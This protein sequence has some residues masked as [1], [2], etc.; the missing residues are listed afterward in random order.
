[1]AM[2]N[3]VKDLETSAGMT[4]LEVLIGII[5]FAFGILA[6]VQLQSSMARS[7]SDANTRTVAV[8]IA[9]ETIE[10]KRGFSRLTKDPEGIEYAYADIEPGQYPVARGGQNYN[11]TINVTDYW[12]NKN[13]MSFTTTEPAVAAVSDFKLMTVNVNWGEGPEFVIDENTSTS[14]RLGSGSVTLSEIISSVTS[15]ADAKSATGGTGGIYLPSI[16]YNPGSNPEIISISLGENK[17]KESTKPVPKVIRADS[18]AETTFDVVTY[19]QNAEGATFL[20]REE[21]RA[22]ACNCSLQIPS[23][24]AQG[25]HRPTIWDGMSYTEGEFVSKPYGIS[26]SNVQSKLCDICCRDHHDGGVG[27]DDDANDPGRARYSPFRPPE[28]YVATGSFA[29]DHKHYSRNS[30]GGLTLATTQGSGYMESCRMVRKN[31]FWK[32]AQDLRQEGLNVFPENFLDSTSEVAIYSKYIT[33]AIE[34]YRN[35]VG[36]TNGYE[37]SPPV[38]TEA[39]NM[40]PA[41]VFPAYNTSDPTYLPTVLGQTSQQLRSRGIYVDYMSDRLRV[42]L[43]C[44][45]AG[46][47]STECEAPNITSPLEIMPFYDVQLTWLSRWNETPLNNPADVT[48]QAIATNNTHSRGNALRTLGTGNTTV[49]STVHSGNLGLTATDPIDPAYNTALRSR[50]LYMQVSNTN[51]P[52]AVNE[53]LISGTISSSIPGFKAADVEISYTGAQCNRTNT[54][55]ICVIEI[56]AS[57]PRITVTNYYANNQNRLGCSSVMVTNGSQTGASG[58]TRFNLPG[59]PTTTADIVIKN[60]SC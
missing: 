8:N 12:Y 11:T 27:S 17:F 26:T 34:L 25:G 2:K 59:S 55:Y 39:A 48:N 47:T 57:N 44:L 33:D 10:L 36:N 15:A 28:D 24:N 38:L 4:L 49:D 7:A 1:M 3:R 60:N 22:I 35:Q 23:T 40:I 42:I 58:W 18:L 41:V 9:E 14:G 20:R 13:S 6:L 32:V 37:T 43:N 21:F 31:G 46:G 56:G 51:A 16:N 50:N 54:G 29:G 52:P 45:D 30:S 5:I 19:S 53:F